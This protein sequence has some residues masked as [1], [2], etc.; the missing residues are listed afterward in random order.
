MILILNKIITFFLLA[1]F[2]WA[3]AAAGKTVTL[4]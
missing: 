2:I 3:D 1:V 4:F